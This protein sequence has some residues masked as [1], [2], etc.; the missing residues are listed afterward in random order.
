MLV[1]T[2]KHMSAAHEAGRINKVELAFFF[3]ALASMI[4]GNR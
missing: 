4:E 3:E 2:I 1:E